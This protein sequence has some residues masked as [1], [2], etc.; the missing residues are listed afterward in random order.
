MNIL[1][2]T[3]EYPNTAYPKKDSPW[4]VPYFAREWVKQGHRVIVIINSTKFPRIC[5]LCVNLIKPI[6][7]KKYNITETNLS[8]RVWAEKFDFVD[9]GVKAYNMPMMKLIPSGNYTD[10]VLKSQIES[11]KKILLENGFV[12][13]IITGHWLN[14]Q[15][16]LISML[17][18]SYKCKTAVVFHS[19]VTQHYIKKYHVKKYIDKI[20]RIGCR[21]LTN[22][23]ILR[24]NLGLKEEPFVCPSGIPDKYIE[25]DL[26]TANRTFADQPLKIISVGRLVGYKR[27][28]TIIKASALLNEDLSKLTV[29]GEG[30]L[31]PK[32][33]EYAAKL[34][35]ESKIVFAG[36]MERDELQ[37]KMRDNDVFVLVSEKEV[38]GLVYLEAMLQG[39]IVVASKGGGVDGIIADGYNGF[40]CEQGNSNELVNILRK[41]RSLSVSEKEKISQ[42]AIQTASEYSDSKTAENYL[43]NITGTI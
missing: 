11:I 2:L 12:P 1:C 3:T 22:A 31:L 33:K 13:D 36:R 5:Y 6:L 26:K 42:N 38:F 28:D 43:R 7:Q 39:C 25:S 10:A 18:D 9:E 37:Q 34:Q 41:I 21:S 19:E 35:I 40:L 16:M 15:L 23:K 32:L 30:Q 14:P 27:F 4:I 24:E 8:S 17:A 20:D 29:I